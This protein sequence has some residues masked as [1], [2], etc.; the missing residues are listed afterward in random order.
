MVF[1]VLYELAF[2]RERHSLEILKG[3]QQPRICEASAAQSCT[4]KWIGCKQLL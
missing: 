1:P 2:E 3:M 4:V